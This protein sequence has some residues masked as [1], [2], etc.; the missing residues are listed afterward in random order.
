MF[1]NVIYFII[2]ILIWSISQ[3]RSTPQESLLYTGSL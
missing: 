2:V 1:N 3:E